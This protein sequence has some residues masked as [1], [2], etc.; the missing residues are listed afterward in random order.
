[1]CNDYVV[2]VLPLQIQFLIMFFENWFSMYPSIQPSVCPSFY[3]FITHQFIHPPIP[4]FLFFSLLYVLKT[5]IQKNLFFF[6]GEQIKCLF[7]SVE[8]DIVYFVVRL[9][10]KLT[11]WAVS[12]Y[13]F[14]RVLSDFRLCVARKCQILSLQYPTENAQFSPA[15]KC[16]PLAKTDSIVSRTVVN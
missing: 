12:M 2:Q 5:S 15:F 16:N 4:V 6:L 1:M 14:P 8:V 11:L 3:P 9:N 7:W 13:F 10:G